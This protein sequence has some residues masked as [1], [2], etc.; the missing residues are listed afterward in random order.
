M[1]VSF[2]SFEMGKMEGKGGK[3]KNIL[4]KLS[5]FWNCVAASNPLATFHPY[6]ADCFTSISIA[7]QR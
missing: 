6:D 4:T 1:L 3:E 5:A 2:E 7:S